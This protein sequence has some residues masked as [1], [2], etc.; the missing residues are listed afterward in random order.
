MSSLCRFALN[1]TICF[2]GSREGI[3]QRKPLYQN[4]HGE[5][6][7]YQTDWLVQWQT[8][9][10][11]CWLN[12]EREEGGLAWQRARTIGQIIVIHRIY[13]WESRFP[14]CLSWDNNTNTIVKS[15]TI[16]ETN[17][18][19][20]DPPQDR[21]WFSF[22]AIHQIIPYQKYQQCWVVWIKSSSSHPQ[23]WKCIPASLISILSVY[24]PPSYCPIDVHSHS[25]QMHW[26]LH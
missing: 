1:E 9:P 16:M 11:R 10:E 3:A 7:E 4:L 18:P 17:N 8:V 19:N 5:K 13:Y 6:H 24:T 21:G 2:S 25:H 20:P 22:S 26:E 15:T 14:W 23:E 12:I